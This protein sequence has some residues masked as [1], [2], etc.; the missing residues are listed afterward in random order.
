MPRSGATVG[1][2]YRLGE[3]LGSGTLGDVYQAH[4]LRHDGPVALKLAH[5][6]NEQP[7]GLS[8]RFAQ[9]LEMSSSGRLSHPRIARALDAGDYLGSPFLVS[10]YVEGTPLLAWFEQIGRDFDRLA[11]TLDSLL[12]ALAVAHSA[13]LAHRSLKSEHILVDAQGQPTLLDFGLA[14]RLEDQLS[15]QRGSQ[16]GSGLAYLSPE[17]IL[18]ERGDA[19]SDLYSLGALLYQ[20]AAGGPPFA[21]ASSSQMLLAHLHQQ[22][23]PLSHLPRPVPPWLDRLVQ[24]LLSKNPS[25]RPTHAGEALSLLRRRVPRSSSLASHVPLA[26][27]LGRDAALAR[28]DAALDGAESGLGSCLWLW[29][30]DG[31]GKTHLLAHLRR[32]AQG[33]WAEW[34]ELSAEAP[35]ALHWLDWVDHPAFG[36]D[37]DP[38]RLG[39][40]S[41]ER[42]RVCVLRGFERSDEALWNLLAE[43]STRVR[44]SPLVLILVSDEGPRLSFRPRLTAELALSGLDRDACAVLLEERLWCP[45]PPEATTWMAQVSE[46]NPFYLSLLLERL[47]GNHLQVDGP[48]AHW[49]PPPAGLECSLEEWLSRELDE[50]PTGF[51]ELLALAACIGPRFAP[52]QIKALFLGDDPG[53]EA[54]LDELTRRN[55]LME[56]W[57]G[58]VASYRFSHRARWKAARARTDKRRARRLVGLV[59]AFLEYP[60]SG[61]ADW[62]RAA[63]CY[64]M[65]GDGAGELR[66]LTRCLLTACLAG[67]W[68]AARAWMRRCQK[69]AAG[70]TDRIFPAPWHNLGWGGKRPS[71]GPR[72]YLATLLAGQGQASEALEWLERVAADGLE[73]DPPRRVENLLL[74]AAFA[75][76]GWLGRPADPADLRQARELAASSAFA[77]GEALASAMLLQVSG[78]R[79]TEASAE[80]E[81]QGFEG[82]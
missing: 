21:F 30:P 40:W 41:E 11:D 2:R 22:P 55:F 26:P 53:L 24:R 29:G 5:S 66:C 37:P 33:R 6:W 52:N 46:G 81:P 50:L 75:V 54:T 49:T 59:G 76:R 63:D 69:P 25:D 48:T 64:A 19:R 72:H 43:W 32:R 15:S 45:P 39:T 18:G 60:Q 36:F 16:S 44:E 7:R 34:V 78:H 9:Q 70:L 14:G 28:L 80:A 51:A 20:L 71:S 4:D 82:L 65:A 35:H 67:K 57:E 13:R 61:S 38:E 31:I 73:D 77:P 23:V 79:A 17:Q 10:E 27:L 74:R 62:A 42:L 12:D 47:E 56:S 1:N 8:G 3:K 58:G 68:D